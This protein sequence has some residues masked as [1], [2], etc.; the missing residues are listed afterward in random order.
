MINITNAGRGAGKTYELIQWA[1]ADPNRRVVGTTNT[2]NEMAVAGIE[3]QFVYLRDAKKTLRG[4]R[5]ITGVAF[6]EF[7]P[8]LSDLIYWE[9]GVTP[10]QEVILSMNLPERQLPSQ[11]RREEHY[12]ELLFGKE[13]L[14][15]LKK[16]YN[17]KDP[18]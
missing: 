4:R 17:T 18:E 11:L 7:G 6:D 16:Q 5:D 14:D 1:K 10:E 12:I 3:S 15:S 13:Y 2:R 8:W 9:Y